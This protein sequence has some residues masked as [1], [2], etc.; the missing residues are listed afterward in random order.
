MRGSASHDGSIHSLVPAKELVFKRL[1]LVQTRLVRRIPQFGGLNPRGYRTVR[2][3]T[4]SRAINRGILDGDLL[5][6]FEM[7]S[8]DQQEEAA[9]LVSS[10]RETVLYN[11][12]NLRG[13]W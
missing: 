1:Q 5:G 11:L 6:R 3:E 8:V 2:N 7:L 12:E 4:V 13:L 9:R 10:D